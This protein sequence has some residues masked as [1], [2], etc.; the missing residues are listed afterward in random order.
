MHSSIS[1]DVD[2]E[3]RIAK[4]FLDVQNELSMTINNLTKT[5]Q[6]SVTVYYL[7]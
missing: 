6:Y 2:L 7:R 4:I 3:V 1:Y 5:F